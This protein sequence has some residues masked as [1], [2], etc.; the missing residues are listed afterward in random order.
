MSKSLF[1]CYCL[2]YINYW[3][4]QDSLLILDIF[5]WENELK[6]D[7]MRQL[8]PL[9]PD[10]PR[11]PVS[12][13]DEHSLVYILLNIN[14]MYFWQTNQINN[15]SLTITT[16][17]NCVCNPNWVMEDDSL[18]CSP[19]KSLWTLWTTRWWSSYCP[20]SLCCAPTTESL[21]SCGSQPRWDIDR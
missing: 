20:W 9:L 18:L 11:F 4:T 1:F 10:F 5:L 21:L 3:S 14:L 16:V 15:V 12:I 6:K 19:W 2:K 8:L 17:F 13:N 7:L